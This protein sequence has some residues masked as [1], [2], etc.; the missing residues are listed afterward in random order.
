MQEM[1]GKGERGGGVAICLLCTLFCLLLSCTAKRVALP[2]YEGV[3]PRDELAR[4]NSVESIR[5]TFSIEFE[6]DGGVLRGD[7]ALELTQTTLD[8]RVYSL[9]FLV[10]EV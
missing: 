10:A 9:G 6:R 5:S 1:I 7:A 8:M 4:R 2:T 3:D